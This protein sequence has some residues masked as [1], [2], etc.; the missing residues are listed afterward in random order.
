MSKLTNTEARIALERAFGRSGRAC[1]PKVTIH[2]IGAINTLALCGGKWM[3]IQAE[4][5]DGSYY[6]G[7]L[8]FTGQGKAVEVVLDW[9]DTYSV[10]LVRLVR[11]GNALGEVVVATEASGVYFDS[12]ADVCFSVAAGK[13]P[14]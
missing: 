10:R 2:Q 14:A 11:K 7:A 6:V 9:D 8:L 13:V 4:D 5:E 1:D 12:L 3:P